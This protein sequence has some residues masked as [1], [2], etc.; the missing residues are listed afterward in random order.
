VSYAPI[1]VR[2]LVLNVPPAWFATPDDSPPEWAGGS[3]TMVGTSNAATVYS[4][5]P[6]PGGV[7]I[8]VTAALSEPGRV[9]VAAVAAAPGHELSGALPAA[10]VRACANAGGG[11]G[12]TSGLAAAAVTAAAAAGAAAAGA[13]ATVAPAACVSVAVDTAGVEGT[14]T[15]D[16]PGLAPETTYAAGPDT[17]STDCLLVAY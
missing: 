10:A 1:L 8:R 13:G 7:T 16:I 4:Y 12:S 6:N 15:V 3:P 5:N 2:V 14:V 11:T 17:A 9:F